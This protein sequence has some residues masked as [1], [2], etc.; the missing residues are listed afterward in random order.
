M[1]ITIPHRTTRATIFEIECPRHLLDAKPGVR[2]G[3][4]ACRAVAEGIDLR[5]A[6]L[7]GAD[8]SGAVLTGANLTRARLDGADLRGAILTGAWLDGARLEGAVL[9]SALLDGAWLSN[10][11][12]T[13]ARLSNANLTG[14]RLDGAWLTRAALTG[15]NLAGAVLTSAW[16]DGA[17]LPE[18]V[19]VV[20][21][22]DA[23]ILAAIEDGGMLDMEDWHTCDTTHC[24]A[25]WAVVMAGE[26]GRKL[27]E[28]LGTNAAA[29]LIYAASRPGKPVP[30]W[31]ASTANALA[32]LRAGAAN[33]PMT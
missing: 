29:A 16:L 33:D 8:L 11:N 17:N 13:G 23:A 4:A 20:P 25:G 26:T 12:L 7:M 31:Y 19:P 30:D 10:A 1:R 5:G 27:E 32:D 28:R 15:A 9:T 21:H 6:V 2:L 14:A 3:W 18:G 24:Q 22:I